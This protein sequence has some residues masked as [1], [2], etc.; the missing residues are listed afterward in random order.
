MSITAI[1][2]TGPVMESFL[3]RKGAIEKTVDP[4]G[5]AQKPAAHSI[6]GCDLATRLQ[7]ETEPRAG[8]K[9]RAC[10][11]RAPL[12]SFEAERIGTSPSLVRHA[13]PNAMQLSVTV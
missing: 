12:R 2:T 7:F 13:V 6:V 3:K 10:A 9:H 11:T 8:G 4:P 1:A 5:H